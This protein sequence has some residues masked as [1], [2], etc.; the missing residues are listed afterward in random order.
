MC[1]RTGDGVRV[2]AEP[3]YGRGN[4]ESL[5]SVDSVDGDADVCA[6]L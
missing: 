6:G 4:T 1:V 2:G 5:L 3:L